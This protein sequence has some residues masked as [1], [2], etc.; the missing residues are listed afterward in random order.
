VEAISIRFGTPHFLHLLLEK[1]KG[2]NPNNHIR[3]G[4]G[5]QTT[6][7]SRTRHLSKFKPDLPTNRPR[8]M[9]AE[10]M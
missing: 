2:N 4:E 3:I 1:G 6:P 7:T 9:G 10:S 8:T 5:R